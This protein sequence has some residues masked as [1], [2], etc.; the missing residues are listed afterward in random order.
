MD[1]S[2]IS[3]YSRLLQLLRFLVKISR[4]SWNILIFSSFP[5]DPLASFQ[6]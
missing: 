3:I 1:D 5:Q 4:E 2:F 6:E